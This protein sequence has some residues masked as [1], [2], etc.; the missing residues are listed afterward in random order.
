M[1]S[2]NVEVEITRELI[3]CLLDNNGLTSWFQPIF[4]RQSGEIY[5]YE[6]LAR[7]RVQQSRNLARVQAGGQ[8][9]E[10]LGHCSQPA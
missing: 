4:S 6:A 2:E 7:P 3:V 9:G 1:R 5:G 8:A 10:R